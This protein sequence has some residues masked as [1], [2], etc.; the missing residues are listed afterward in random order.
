MTVENSF[1]LVLY[2]F[3]SKTIYNDIRWPFLLAETHPCADYQ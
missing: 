3:C 2:E 1:F